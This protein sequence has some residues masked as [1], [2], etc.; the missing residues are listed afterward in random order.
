LQK[1]HSYFYN[2]PYDGLRKDE[3]GNP[4]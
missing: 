2:E 3:I 4:L 1:P